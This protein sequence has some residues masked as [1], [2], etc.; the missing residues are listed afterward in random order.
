MFEEELLANKGDS[1]EAT[2]IC[3]NVEVEIE[4]VSGKVGQASEEEILLVEEKKSVERERSDK[5][6]SVFMAGAG[7]ETFASWPVGSF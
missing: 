6:I 4:D 5:S 1:S 3:P 7:G 2:A